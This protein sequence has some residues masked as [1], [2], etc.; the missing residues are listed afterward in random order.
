MEAD[1]QVIWIL[2]SADKD[3]KITA[4]YVKQTKSWTKYIQI[5]QLTSI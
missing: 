2:E 4:K 3:L 1:P 5:W